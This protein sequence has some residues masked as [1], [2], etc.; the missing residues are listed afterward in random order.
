MSKAW[1]GTLLTNSLILGLGV[2]TG[3]ITA[4]LL[5]PEGRGLL[6]AILFWPQLAAGLGLFS[7]NEATV[8]GIGREPDR[9][10]QIGAAATAMAVPLA[11]VTCAVIFLALPTLLGPQRSGSWRLATVYAVAFIPLNF[12][13]L[14]SLAVHQGRLR[15]SQYNLLR[16]LT[17]MLYLTGLI[18]L[19]A[20]GKATV[21]NVIVVNLVAAAG[22]AAACTPLLAN[23]RRVLPKWS[24]F[25]SLIRTIGSF[26]WAAALMIL[27]AEADR[28]VAL[29]LYD[30][31]TV[32]YYIVAF[33]LASVGY[34]ALS[35]ASFTV[36]MP[37]LASTPQ[38]MQPEVLARGIRMAMFTLILFGLVLFLLAP[39]LVVL[40]FGSAFAPAGIIARYLAVALLLVALKTVIVRSIRGLGE[41]RPGAIAEGVA[42]ALFV[43][44]AWPLG[45][46]LGPVGLALALIGASLPAIAYLVVYL[47]R[48]YDLNP[49]SLWGLRPATA[50]EIIDSLR[51]PGRGS[52]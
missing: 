22:L 12:F 14:V 32:G 37:Q 5:L 51:T 2:V 7:L 45:T 23:L 18:A 31:I 34:V 30:D 19:W 9:W 44:M 35:S 13:T 26:H 47:K 28:L 24:D 33:T 3:I 36:L 15:F 25:R 8:F 48:A 38:K 27:A 6:A 11:V 42:L 46:R 41:G 20:L 16:T 43:A 40:L 1:G 17:P 49:L 39:Y 52:L 10:R 29:R 4:R 50:R 21:A